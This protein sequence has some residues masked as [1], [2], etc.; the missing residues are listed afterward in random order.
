ME[1]SVGNLIERES[2]SALTKL[3]PGSGSPGFNE[4]YPGNQSR[5]RK[6]WPVLAPLAVLA[7]GFSLL[8]PNG[9]HQWALSIFRQPTHNTVL[10]FNKAW[11]LPTT[12]IIRAPMPISFTIEND[13]GRTV[14]YQYILS[15]SGDGGH[16]R[17]FGESA[18]IVRAGGTWNVST[19]IRPDCN[20]L[21]CRIEVSLPGYPEVIDFLVILKK[22]IAAPGDKASP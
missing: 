9:R 12:A 8:W 10:F 3:T 6:W 19:T 18:R 21:H 15:V 17:V 20:N 2:E 1:R 4:S 14:N 11:S 16:S 13:E 7:I 5:E 22:G